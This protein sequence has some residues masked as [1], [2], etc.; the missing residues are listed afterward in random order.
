M[1]ICEENFTNGKQNKNCLQN[2]RYPS[3]YKQRKHKNGRAY[4]RIPRKEINVFIV[5]PHFLFYM[6][7]ISI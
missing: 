1:Q 5:R 4:E 2:P 6:Q 7:T 3:R